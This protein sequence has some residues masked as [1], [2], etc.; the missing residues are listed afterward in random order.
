MQRGERPIPEGIITDTHIHIP[1][2]PSPMP[3]DPDAWHAWLPS[4]LKHRAE[5]LDL[6]ATD[7]QARREVRA[8]CKQPHGLGV[9][10][11]ICTFGWIHEPRKGAESSVMPWVPYPRQAELFLWREARMQDDDPQYQSGLCSKARGVGAT[12]CAAGD[13]LHRWLFT[14]LF[15]GR[16]VS[17]VEEMVDKKGSSDSWMW[18][19]DFILDRLP[20]WLL[21]AGFTTPAAH[22]KHRTHLM[23]FNPQNSSAIKGEATT[24]GVGRGG[25]ATVYDIDEGAHYPEFGDNWNTL[26]E[27]TDHRFVWSTEGVD[28]N[29]DFFN[30]QHGRDGYE[31]PGIF[32]F[33]WHQVP[34]RDKTWYEGKKRTMKREDFEREVNR[35]PF[36]AS[37]RWV[38][39]MA[40]TIEPGRFPYK[41]G[42]PVY[43]G[44]DDGYDDDTAIVWAQR[45]PVNNRIRILDS[46]SNNHQTTHFYGYLL[47][48][49]PISGKY[50][51]GPEEIS[52]MRWI[53]DH[54]LHHATF[55]GDRHGDNTDMNSG[56][57]PFQ[58]LSDDFGIYVMT[59]PIPEKN[60]IKGRRDALG[61]MLTNIE[62]NDTDGAIAWLDAV[63]GN[64]FPKRKGQA[65]SELRKPVHDGSSHLTTA[66]EYIAINLEVLSSGPANHG[67]TE[68]ATVNRFAQDWSSPA[69]F[70]RY[71]RRSGASGELYG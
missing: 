4:I 62:V 19:I 38:Y 36:A 54:N 10:F 39:P 24:S 56:K 66:G 52:L 65:A 70:R 68:R 31:K 5:I 50:R 51:W 9:L 23:L 43:V 67:P 41:P 61:E 53:R 15:Q 11:F 59:C 32:I 27:T 58:V 3:R 57:S 47:S 16:L 34:G 48:G 69:G 28:E 63:K 20:K 42:W 21:P 49:N 45:N 29:M 37:S 8:L 7:A 71:T 46:Y 55:F 30:L 35:N 14:P 26:A 1:G 6:C 13:Q 25:R 22:C 44:I 18:K 2:L 17:R 12:W 64:Q 40:A 60:T 33:H